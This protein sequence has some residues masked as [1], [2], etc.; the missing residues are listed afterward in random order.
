MVK[1]EPLVQDAVHGTLVNRTNT[2]VVCV[3]WRAELN[4]SVPVYKVE[5]SEKARSH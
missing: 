5:L 3:G 4:A 2:C 1:T